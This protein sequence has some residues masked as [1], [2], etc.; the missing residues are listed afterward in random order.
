MQDDATTPYNF[1]TIEHKWQQRWQEMALFH[2]PDADDGREKYTCLTMFPYPSG[3]RLH[4]GHGRNYILAD[5]VVRYKIMQG[6][7]VLSPMGWDAFGLPAENDAIKKGIA[8][9]VSVRRNIDAMKPQ[10]RRWGVGYDW[11]RELAT[12]DPAYY[13]WTQW[14]FLKLYERDLAYRK[15]APVNWCPSCKTVLAN[16]QV[17][18]DGSC[19]RCASEVSKK[20]LTQWF[21]HITSYA[22]RL[23]DGLETLGTWPERVKALQRNWIGRSH[24]TTIVFTLDDGTQL[25]VF[26]TR[27]DTLFGVT[28]VSL[29][30]EHPLVA[31]ASD[32][33]RTFARRLAALPVAERSAAAGGTDGAPKEGMPTGLFATNPANDERVPIFVAS[34][35][36]MEYGTGAVMAVPAHD[37]RDFEFAREHGLPIRVVISPPDR[38]LD[39]AE[40]EEA[41]VEPGVMVNSD[42]FSGL[43]ND[44]G[45]AKVTDFLK[46]KER[47]GRVTSFRLRDWLV[48]R[49]RYWGAPIPIVYCDSCGEQPVP[50]D[51]LPVKLPHDAGF[52]VEVR[53]SGTGESPLAN[54]DEWVQT[55]CPKCGG[56]ARRETDTMDTFVD[57]S[58]YYLRYTGAQDA[59][60][61]FDPKRVAKWLPV[62]QYIG[63]AE[64]ATKH[65]IYAR[66]ITKFLHDLELLPFTEP[67]TN[68]FSQGLICRVA[69]KTGRLE[70]MS[71]SKGNA[72]SPDALIASLGADSQRLYTLFLGPPDRDVEWQDDGIGG[73]H[74]FLQRL[75]A[76]AQG[77]GSLPAQTPDI[78]MET[79]SA[80]YAELVRKTHETIEKVTRDIEGDFGFNT[81]VAALMELQNEARA[82]QQSESSAEAD[83]VA[84]GFWLETTLLLLAPMAPHIAEELWQQ[85]KPGVDES[86]FRAAWPTYDASKAKRDE[87]EIAVQ[88]NG[89]VRCREQ[90]PAELG[91]AELEAL[92]LK[93]TRVIEAIG[94]KTIRK[95][96]VV[97]GRLVNV[98]V[99]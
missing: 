16:E 70:K 29:A 31:K 99:S 33:A 14:L 69:E 78:D 10:F 59:S 64:H 35:A 79:L 41:Y 43:P 65:L 20:E 57:S 15:Q 96:V 92:V 38:E 75:W 60:C 89:K 61:A 36:L 77:I 88:V 84:L 73:C 28:F 9:W 40:M 72:V 82:T 27:P 90:V 76:L 4:V 51:Q 48:S 8:P 91:K 63:G 87:V 34:Y 19:E 45:K 13:R 17:E 11:E 55:Q 42:A 95:V 56:A 85:L 74:K 25:P 93:R 39:V 44:E 83:R 5:V 22:N 98:V 23:I 30:P 80:P 21:F 6:F 47:G 24:G 86:I 66:F 94:D 32:E 2:A 68:L 1:T 62:A 67:F 97:P 50:E 26:T 58:W 54:V 7:N 3:D 49:Q 81:A 53:A 71:K 18:N 46:D 37:Q 12:C 52:D